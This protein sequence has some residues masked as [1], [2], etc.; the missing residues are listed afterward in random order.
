MHRHN[1]CRAY[2][3]EM[4]PAGTTFAD[5]RP[6][7]AAARHAPDLEL[8]RRRRATSSASSL[9]SACH[10]A[11]SVVSGMVRRGLSAEDPQHRRTRR[12]RYDDGAPTDAAH[13]D[14]NGVNAALDVLVRHGL[15]TPVARMRPLAV[16]H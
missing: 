2:P 16:L 1:A 14:D 6:G 10:G 11:G 3:A 7:G 12:Y 4:M 8:P 13:Y 15:V 9:H 5:D